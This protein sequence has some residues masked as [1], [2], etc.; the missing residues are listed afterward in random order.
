MYSF[1]KIYHEHDMTAS[2]GFVLSLNYLIF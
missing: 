2:S 1:Q